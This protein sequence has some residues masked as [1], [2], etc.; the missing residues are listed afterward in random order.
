VE[1]A[2]IGLDGFEEM[3]NTGVWDGAGAASP[4]CHPLAQITCDAQAIRPGEN[5]NRAGKPIEP[6]KPIRA[7]GKK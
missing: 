3:P 5:E 7:I 2:W 4:N 6:A 1:R